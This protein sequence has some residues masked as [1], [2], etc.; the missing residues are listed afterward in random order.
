M[1]PVDYLKANPN[2]TRKDVVRAC[3]CSNREARRAEDQLRFEQGRPP[4]WIKPLAG[5]TLVVLVAGAVGIWAS[6]REEAPGPSPEK[7]LRA[8]EA[9]IYSALDA[10]DQ[11]QVARVS[12]E[13]SSPDEP[14]RIAALRFVATVDPLPYLSNLLPMVDDPSKRVRSAAVQLLG[15]VEG[16][17]SE[18]D[19]IAGTLVSVLVDSERE[20]GERV[21]A[22]AGLQKGS[23]GS[24]HARRLLPVLDDRQ[25]ATHVGGLLARWLG[26][27]V[28]PAEGE[29]LRQAWER[30]LQEDA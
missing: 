6:Q 15:R 20:L 2:A 19:D 16:G 28:T 27:T 22:V 11:T 1:D 17:P 3:G 10:R 30:T 8:Q 4:G 14:V 23:E 25:L 13:L 29:S 5:I 12:K 18:A 24:Q 9:S 7:D 21:L 26:K